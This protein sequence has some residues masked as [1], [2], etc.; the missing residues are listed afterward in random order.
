MPTKKTIKHRKERIAI[1]QQIC[2]EDERLLTVEEVL[3]RTTVT[4]PALWKWMKDGKFPL[5]RKIC[6]NRIGWLKSEV[7]AWAK[8][9]PPN[10]PGHK[11]PAA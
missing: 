10:V 6:S 4:Y 5:A 1:A 3:A 11:K 9:L 8:N 7:D 2:G